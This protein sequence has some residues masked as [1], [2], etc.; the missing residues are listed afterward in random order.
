VPKPYL[1]PTTDP[2]DKVE[3]IALKNGSLKDLVNKNDP[4]NKN[5]WVNGDQIVRAITK[6]NAQ[7]K[8][9]TEY[10]VPKNGSEVHGL[11]GTS[12]DPQ[13][14][15]QKPPTEWVKITPPSEDQK[16]VS[17]DATELTQGKQPTTI[18]S[19]VNISG[20]EQQ[21]HKRYNA[22][23][24]RYEDYTNPT[25]TEYQQL[26][27][28]TPRVL[29]GSNLRNEIGMAMFNS[30]LGF[31]PNNAPQPGTTE[32]DLLK[33]GKWQ[34]DL[35]NGTTLPEQYKN[36]PPE[37]QKQKQE[38]FKRQQETISKVEAK[39]KE[40]GG[41]NAKVTT[42]PITVDVSDAKTI[43]QLPLF[44]VTGKDGKDRFVDESGRLYQDTADW[45]ANNKLPP[46]RVSYF[47]DGH[48]HINDAKDAKPK[49][50]TENSHAVIDTTGER[51]KSVADTVLPWLGIAAGAVLIAS[52][53]GAPIGAG[54][55]AA[56][57]V[58]MAGV[59]AYG[60]SQ[61]VGNYNDRASHGQSTTDL[62]DAEVRGMWLGMTADALSTA[63]PNSKS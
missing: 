52:G 34:G 63:I 43:L 58:T 57:T 49:V 19:T 5:V 6:T 22:I 44:R 13:Q 42:L 48:I 46:G 18:K 11:N 60:L 62:S 26:R 24:Q 55:I 39:I 38:Q 56:A 36:L 8:P 31:T 23:S 12:S 2:K 15:Q 27:G 35:F 45:K 41:E 61:G 47:A 9:V 17:V 50:I 25:F 37:Q 14:Q 1:T 7:G 40:V 32:A 28:D 4:T 51:V 16:I 59:G 54:L 10:F 29:T 21:T 20:A 30:S 53:F 33:Q 3:L